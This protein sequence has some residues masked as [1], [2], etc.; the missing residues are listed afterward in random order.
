MR[1]LLVSKIFLKKFIAKFQHS[2]ICRILKKNQ[3]KNALDALDALD[4]AAYLKNKFEIF[5]KK[6]HMRDKKKNYSF[7]EHAL[8]A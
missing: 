6:S 7:F 8:Y 3:K 4:A 5:F 2:K 1:M